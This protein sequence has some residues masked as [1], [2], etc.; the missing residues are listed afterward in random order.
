M[1]RIL[2]FGDSLTWGYDPFAHTRFDEE[3]RWTGVLQAKLNDASG[4]HCV[5]IEEGQNGRTIATD[6]PAEGE[7]NGLTYIVPCLESHRPLDLLIIMLG[8]NDCKIRFGYAAIDIASEM[9][10]FLE[11]VIAFRHFRCDD[12]FKI[13]LIAPPRIGESI[14]ESWLGDSFGFEHGIELSGGLAPWYEQLSQMY[15]CAFL[16]ASKIVSASAE[17]AVHLDAENQRKLGA[18][19][20]EFIIEERLI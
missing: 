15:G 14:R 6:D 18:A 9:Q 4:T 12:S 7:K 11:K 3:D 17:D 19:I 8:S 10:R 2:C 16:D 13:L 1:K 20:A 5:I